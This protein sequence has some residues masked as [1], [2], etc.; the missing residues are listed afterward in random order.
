MLRIVPWNRCPREPFLN[1][2]RSAS[3]S[4]R[5]SDSEMRISGEEDIKMQSA[6]NRSR[7]TEQKNCHLPPH[8]QASSSPIGLDAESSLEYQMSWLG[9]L[10]FFPHLMCS[11]MDH[12]CLNQHGTYFREK[13][14]LDHFTRFSYT[15]I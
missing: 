10:F 8:C 2:L 11:K 5:G 9:H 1:V 4:P 14:V 13:R 7:Q 12:V 3:T 6:E 15:E